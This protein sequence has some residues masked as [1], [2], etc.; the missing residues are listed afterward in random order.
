MAHK[1]SYFPAQAQSQD[2]WWGE[3]SFEKKVKCHGTVVLRLPPGEVT[4]TFNASDTSPVLTENLKE[5]LVRL[6][7]G[8]LWTHGD[9]LGDQ[10]SLDK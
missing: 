9:H 6:G 5:A 8:K 10:I 2:T 7:D 1:L 4:D 3:V